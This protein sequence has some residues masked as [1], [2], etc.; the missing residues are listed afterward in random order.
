MN[1]KKGGDEADDPAAIDGQARGFLLGN[2]PGQRLQF[3]LIAQAQATDSAGA[4]SPVISGP[5]A[6]VSELQV[7]TA[8]WQ[9]H[10]SA[11]RLRVYTAPCISIG[12]G[13]CDEG[14]SEIF[15]AKQFNPFPLHKKATS[16][17]WYVRPDNIR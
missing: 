11:G 5:N 7:V 12:F 6:T 1:S 9:V 8:N 16:N 4:K 10:M 14:F 13:T 17:D 15:L 3:R 2:A